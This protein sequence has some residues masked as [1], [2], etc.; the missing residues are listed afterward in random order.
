[1]RP[2]YGTLKYPRD[3][4]MKPLLLFLATM[5]VLAPA[6]AQTPKYSIAN[7]EYANFILDNT[8][9]TLYGSGNGATGIGSNSGFIGLPIPCKFP[10]SSIKIKFAAAGLHTAS[11][12]DVNGNVYF[13]GA[14]ED[15]SM[16]N[17]TTTG[18]SSS[19]VQVM[20]D[21][22]GHPFTNVTY[23]R[24]ASAIFTGGAG[25]GAIIFAIKADGTLWVWGNTKGG[26]AGNGT[27]GQ[28]NTRPTQVPFPAGTV[29]T[30]V[31]VQ[32][33]AIALDANGNVWTWAGNGTPDLLGNSSQ[34][35]YETPHQIS[36]PSPAMDIAGGGFFSYALLA[37]H[38]LYG[39][40]W[41]TGYMGVGP[42]PGSGVVGMNP[43]SKPMLL[44]PSLNLPNPIS[45]LST[46]GTSTYVI[47]SDGTLWAWG[48]NE[49]GQIGNGQEINWKKYTID[50][51]PYN[52]A[53][54][55]PYNWNQDASTAQLQQHKPIQ[56]APGINNFVG[57]SEGVAAVFYKCAVDNNG[58][59]YSWG[60]NKNGVLANGVIEGEFVD[61]E[62]GANYP[63]SFD[64][65]YI[66]AINPFAATTNILS[67]SPECIYVPGANFCN[68]YRIPANTPPVSEING[69]RNGSSN[70][71]NV[72]SV[73]LDGTGSHDNVAI[74]YYVWSQI[75]G[76]NSPIISIPSGKKVNILG[77][78]TGTY[79]FQLKTIDNGWM[80]DSTRYTLNVNDSAANP[81][82]ASAG[83]NQ[84]IT[85]PSNSVTLKGSGS[86]T[87]GTIASYLWTKLSG[88][89]SFTILNPNQAQTAV[90]GMV[91]GVYMFQLKVTDALGVSATATVQ[92]T[93]NPPPAGP[94]S[95]NA[96]PDQT[97]TLPTNSVTLTGSGSETNGTIVS[98]LWTQL[99]GPSNSNINNPAHAQ[100]QVTALVQGVYTFQLTVTDSV[101]NKATDVAKVT[102]KSAII[103]GLPSANAGPDQTIT[104]PTNS[105]TL[106]GSGSETNGTIVSYLWTQLSGPST[107]T[108]IS[109]TQA[110]T[111]VSGMVQGSYTFQLTVTDNSGNKATDVVI[112]TVKPAIVVGPPVANAGPDQT[113]TL[114][115]NTVTLTGSGSETN[116]TI[117][118]YSWIQVGGPSASTIN[119]AD[120]PQ[121]TVSALKAGT[122]IFQL[123]VTDASGNKATD[124]AKITV[125]AAIVVGPPIANAGPDQTITLP[126]NTVTLAGTG[127]ETN[128]TIVSYQ[129][130]QLS[131]PS[132]SIVNPAD[133]PQT[134]V[135]ALLAGTY[136]FQLTVTDASGNKATD[137][138]KITVNAAIVVGSPVANAGP[139]QSI[140]L[141][142]NTV[143]LTG[144]GSETNG[145]ITSYAW[146]QLSGPSASI[147]NSSDQAQTTVSA[148]LA[149]TYL[150]QLTVTDAS[151]NKATDVAK[152]TV[153]AAIV[154]PG[155]PVVNAGSNQIIT[156]PINSVTLTAVASE[157]N[158]TIVSYQWSQISGPTTAVM[159]TASSTQTIVS[160]L[161]RG[162]YTFQIQVTDSLGVK[163]SDVV[164]VTVNPALI[165]A[166]PV[167][168]AGANQTITLPI[169]TVTL[170][171]VASETN[172]TIVS[173]QWSQISGP[174]TAVMSTAGSTQT[175]VS[176]LLQG[177]YTFQIQVTD[178]LGVKASDL[179]KVTVNPALTQATPVVNAGVNQ[180]I[181]LPVNTVVL[182]A[183]ASETNGTIQSY[184]WVELSGPSAA[185]IANPNQAQTNVTGLLQGV[186][187]FQITVT[188]GFGVTAN[189]AVIVTVNAAVVQGHPVVSAGAN[190]TITLPSDAVNLVATASE[191]NGTITN[192]QWSQLSGPSVSSIA[193][194]N[195][196]VTAIT[197]LV[198]GDYVFQVTVTDSLGNTA[199]SVVEVVVNPALVIGLPVANAGP[200][201]TITLPAD[202]VTLTGT[203]SETNGTIVSYLW[204]QL[205]GPS[206]AALSSAGQAQTTAGPLVAGSYVFQLTVTDNSGV[207]ATDVAIITVNAVPVAGPPSASAGQDQIIFLPVNSV[208][209]TG[210]GSET[211]GTIVTYSW[212]Q[213]IG[214]STATIAPDNQAQTTVSNLIQGTYLFEITV[215]DSAGNQA[216]NVVTITVNPEIN[217]PPVANAG[218]NQTI[219]TT[220][221]T[222]IVTLNGS[223]SYAPSGSII[224]YEWAQVSGAGGVTIAN[225]SDSI[226][227]VYGLN[228]GVYIFQLIVTD[229]LGDTASSQVTIT[230]NFVNSQVP[231]AVAG[232]DTTIAYPESQIM[233]NGSASYELN[234]AITAYN[235]TEVS[236]PTN[237]VLANTGVAITSASELVV[238][239]YVFQ[240]MVRDDNNDSS[241]SIIHVNVISTLRSL[242]YIS[243]YPNPFIGNTINING[244]I[245]GQGRI[246]VALYDLNGK[247][248]LL[249]TY[250]KQTSQ[251]QQNIIVPNLAKGCY[252]LELQFEGK[253]SPYSFKL[254]KQ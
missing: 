168:N 123:T 167:V 86:E 135:S 220:D 198:A 197:G 100:T 23:L 138:A 122:Y 176:G 171:A 57:L 43:P 219:N 54:P 55:E 83:S 42:N 142:T 154:I 252:I 32:N 151:G 140:T 76:P 13:T 93:V 98:Y 131:G 149:G 224:G 21:N 71:G 139:D 170:T 106:T 49:C 209:L 37:N 113:I 181:T 60:R 26:Y 173:Y 61:G 62:L 70:V 34:N 186:Y 56:I 243:V 229:N 232:K 31:I 212:T 233:L 128:G 63:N 226:A 126:T 195:Q 115:T 67:T 246:G 91:Q 6:R 92:V 33:V 78:T 241:T 249:N 248:V 230:V 85:L 213:V 9:Q 210:S 141:P 116:G 234:G 11:C 205:S 20:T 202:S 74:V 137:V 53:I 178:S 2:F 111:S 25:Y 215:T 221:S 158:G 223:A 166:T 64:V 40:G 50:P 192:Y 80:G 161:I 160:G 51:A 46:N 99:S 82:V 194:A 47:L 75:S 240:L 65:P 159:S 7:G 250:E 48:G 239:E 96:G 203:G 245:E 227:S 228:P 124:V 119:T 199:S 59:L 89:S 193:T 208:T 103:V 108:I 184:Q 38:S 41:Y 238:G 175:I 105:V 45:I 150:F 81:P 200:N 134:T 1:M 191:T 165:Q 251:F 201:Q 148:L 183:T 164:K 35:D 253:S 187:S 152:I 114:P 68:L 4:T 24:M 17:G 247:R 28:V 22:L 177:V 217:L 218:F 244:S 15:G 206:A 237:A 225:S 90:D 79:V 163:A 5:W 125:N 44:D 121:T 156:L 127:S 107:S 182:T 97:I 39:W 188:D 110:Q 12:I 231:V 146:T 18:G 58:Q 143:T 8:T 120:Q 109:A 196:A 145:T 174:A 117:V 190:Q 144:T 133:Q 207:T 52:G 101:G 185:S 214:P 104:L 84:T 236:G 147:I 27:Y 14:N 29:I 87:N 95:A 162:V 16:G 130:T 155:S 216:T 69:T 222:V 118:S 172:G 211:N 169:N 30:K 94:P 129:W 3:P 77:L 242:E 102:V 72:S 204:S 36:L 19:F 66:T 73:V 88:P 157:T 112:V 235:W 180:T 179:V 136:L 10:S 254:I 132:A 189:D 153:N